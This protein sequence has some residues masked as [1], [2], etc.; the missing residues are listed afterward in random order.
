MDEAVL[1]TSQVNY[2][3]SETEHP[4]GASMRC[5][6]YVAFVLVFK[7]YPNILGSYARVERYGKVVTSIANVHV[8]RSGTAVFMEVIHG[9][10]RRLGLK[11]TNEL[12]LAAGISLSREVGSNAFSPGSLHPM[13]ERPK[14]DGVYREHFS[15]PVHFNAERDALEGTTTASIQKNRLSDDSI[16]KFF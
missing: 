6:D 8:E 1:A 11:R 5:N 4:L 10:D 14:D 13:A 7:S 12:V 2:R 3:F 16:P 9:P 15:C